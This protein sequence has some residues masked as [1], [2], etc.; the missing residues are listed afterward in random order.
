MSMSTSFSC[1]RD[2]TSS[3]R[4]NEI[5][6]L[7][8]SIPSMAIYSYYASCYAAGAASSCIRLV[9]NPLDLVKT[10][11]Q[12]DTTRQYTTVLAGLQLIVKQDGL[13]GLFHG[14]GPTAMSYMVQTGMKY[15]TY[16]LFK[17]IIL[18]ETFGKDFCH[19]NKDLVYI[20]AA[21]SAEAIAD[22]FMCP[23]EM[24]KIKVQTS[25]LLTGSCVSPSNTWETLR[26]MIRYR[27]EYNFPFGALGPLWMR[28]IPG[29]I[30]N[31]YTFET[32][33]QLIY[34][35]ILP[36]QKFINEDSFA[37]KSFVTLISGYTAGFFSSVI[38]HPADSLVS[39][40]SQLQ[41]QHLTIQQ[42]IQSVGIVRLATHG[43]GPRIFVTGNIICFQ[44]ILYDSFKSILGATKFQ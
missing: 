28:Q 34:K 24:L 39:L 21:A 6:A 43:L 17:D 44:W 30:A 4:S 36:Q 12:V 32:T 25:A 14:V 42:I 13:A 29:T 35:Q 40:R 8:P 10:R 2:R 11:M 1:E 26:H 41:Y 19:N 38:S 23:W 16:E 3:V 9:M 7:S 27:K 20:A 37:T 18:P 15:G 22:V 31:F 33:S 5:M